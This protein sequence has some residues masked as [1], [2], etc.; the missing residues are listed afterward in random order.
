MFEKIKECIESYNTIIIH[1]HKNPD[2]DALGS[3][4]GLK[5]ILRANY[6]EKRILCVGESST[7]FGFMDD[8]VM[9]DVSD[10]DYEDAL[11]I[12]L[13][14]SAK[15]LISDDRYTLAHMT[16][17]LDHHIFCEKIAEVEVTDTSFESCCG[18]ITAMAVE[19]GWELTPIAAKSLYTGMVTDSGRF[20]YDSTTSKTFMLASHLLDESFDIGDIYRNLYVDDFSFI[21]LR[22]QFVLKIQFTDN[23]KVAYIYT[24]YEEAQKYG[25][26]SFTLSRGMVNVMGEIRGVEIWV[27]FTETDDGVLC[28]LRS[29]VHNINPIAKKYGGGGHAKASGATLADKNAAMQMLNDLIKITEE[30]V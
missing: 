1:R 13:D 3:Q 2:G 20:R 14:T 25:V 4:I 24:T 11:A 15:A 7:R 22:A 26:D 5:N 21:K 12:I 9:D 10:K 17:R 27:N 28:E 29:S 19:C 16:A 8:S 6:P 30:S 18:L 23:A